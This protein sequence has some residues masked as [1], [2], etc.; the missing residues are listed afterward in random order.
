MVAGKKLSIT[1]TEF[2]VIFGI[3]SGNQDI[4]MKASSVEED[5]L[6]KRK[7]WDVLNITPTHLETELLKSMKGTTPQDIEDTIKLLILHVMACVLF[8]ASSDVVRWWMLRICEDLH[9]LR[10]YN[11]GK[12]VVGYLMK[13]V[14]TSPSEEVRGCTALLQVQLHRS[15]PL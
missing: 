10:N 7:F 11:W 12:S 15:L 6:E 3:Y 2:E 13:F 5:F 4:D 14:Q 9:A 8:I 1:P